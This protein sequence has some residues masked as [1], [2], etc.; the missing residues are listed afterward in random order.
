MQAI[1]RF[2]CVSPQCQ[3]PQNQ[4]S[5]L[6]LARSPQV[7]GLGAVFDPLLFYL[8]A[9]FG[10]LSGRYLA[11]Q[12]VFDTTEELRVL[13]YIPGFG[14]GVHFEL[15]IY[16]GEEVGKVWTPSLSRNQRGG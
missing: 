5:L 7:Q 15:P 13:V 12:R 14:A 8:L 2:L 9:D 16:E 11:L 1:S 10:D 4:T 6:V 3:C